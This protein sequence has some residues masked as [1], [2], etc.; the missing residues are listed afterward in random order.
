MK[1]KRAGFRYFKKRCRYWIERFGLGDW[2][3]EYKHRSRGGT[4]AECHAHYDHFVVLTLDK[5]CDHPRQ[6]RALERAA[7]HEV[8][9]LLL[10]ELDILA[11]AR[12]DVH[13]KDFDNAR[14]TIINRL[15]ETFGLNG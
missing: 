5:D 7:F 1:T 9:E 4:Q 2:E 12:L 3:V 11:K 8:C 10:A 15:A 6:R 14:H 13:D